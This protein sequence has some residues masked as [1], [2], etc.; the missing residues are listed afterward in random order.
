METELRK[1]TPREKGVLERLLDSAIHSRDEL[2]TQLDRIKAVQIAEDGSLSLQCE[3]GV[4]AQ[5]KYAPVSEATVKDADGEDIAVILH[6]GNGGFMSILEIIKY[7]GSQI[8]KPPSAEDLVLL[9]PEHPGRKA[10]D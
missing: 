6:L 10:S 1:L 5:G 4:P 3:G 9:W 7:D 8:I 2:R